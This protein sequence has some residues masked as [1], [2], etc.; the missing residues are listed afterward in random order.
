MQNPLGS[1]GRWLVRQTI[2]FCEEEVEE[3]RDRL[4]GAGRG[5]AVGTGVC[6]D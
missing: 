3:S 1:A 5:Q 4:R 6:I 2:S